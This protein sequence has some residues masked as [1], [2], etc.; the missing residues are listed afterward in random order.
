MRKTY[1]NTGAKRQIFHWK[2]DMSPAVIFLLTLNEEIDRKRMQAALEQTLAAF[3]P[4]AVKLCEDGAGELCFVPNEKNPVVLDATVPAP[5]F[6]SDELGNYLFCVRVF[7]KQMEVAV[8]HVLTDGSGALEFARYLLAAY[9]TQ[10]GKLEKIPE[11]IPQLDVADVGDPYQKYA[12]N[13]SQGLAFATDWKN[14]FT[15]PHPMLYEKNSREYLYFLRFDITELL[16]IAK[17]TDASVYPM[18]A[19]IVC[20]SLHAAY[21]VGEKLIV[22][23]GAVNCRTFYGS[24]TMSNFS[25]SFSLMYKPREL[26]LS[27]ETQALCQRGMMDLSLQKESLDFRIKKAY[28]RFSSMEAGELTGRIRDE[29]Y[30]EEKRQAGAAESAFFLSYVGRFTLPAELDGMVEDAFCYIPGTRNPLTMMAVGVG[31][32]LAL[33]VVQ[34]FPGREFVDAVRAD[35]D[36]VGITVKVEEYGERTFPGT[37]FGSAE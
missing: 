14:E 19:G 8:H 25:S 16:R 20:R 34:T 7:G 13:D 31:K 21:G 35:L 26:K 36:Q 3:P 4:F 15:L 27:L 10:A 33:A 2:D 32:D 11:G 28:R 18:L 9:L 30:W 1:L 6:G 37:V 5:D 23:D 24:R 12:D 17:K 29:A 22:G